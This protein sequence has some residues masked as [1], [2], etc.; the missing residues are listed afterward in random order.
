MSEPGEI[1]GYNLYDE[2]IISE[3]DENDQEEEEEE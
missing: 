2:E 3:A 1:N